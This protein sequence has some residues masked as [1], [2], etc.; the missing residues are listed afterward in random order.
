[1]KLKSLISGVYCLKAAILE[2][3]DNRDQASEA[4]QAALNVDIYCFKAF[5]ALKDHQMLTAI[6]ER[7]L[8]NSLSS[9]DGKSLAMV[10]TA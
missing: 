3:I 4:Y 7:N 8:I 10:R 5:E 6:E 9:S 1:M 2:S